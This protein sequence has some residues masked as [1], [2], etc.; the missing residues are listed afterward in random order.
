M[1]SDI[2]TVDVFTANN[3]ATWSPSVQ[4]F[5]YK[6]SDDVVCLSVNLTDSSIFGAS[7]PTMLRVALPDT[8]SIRL[9]ESSGFNETN[10][11]SFAATVTQGATHVP[12][13]AYASGPHEIT[14]HAV[15]GTFGSGVRVQFA[16]TLELE[17]A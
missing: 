14:I 16:V 8:F 12:V 11:Q 7:P 6:V 13:R 17:V 2:P 15:S 1:W 10:R 4:Y 9:S 5:R 3:G